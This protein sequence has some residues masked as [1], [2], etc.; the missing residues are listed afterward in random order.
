MAASKFQ[1]PPQAPLVFTTTGDAVKQ[2]MDKANDESKAIVD[3]LVAEVK[4]ENATFSSVIEPALKSD[5]E[6]NKGR[7]TSV[8][9]QYVSSDAAVRDGSTKA[10]E[11]W[12]S[13]NIDA[14]MRDDIFK[15]VDA[16]YNTRASQNLDTEKLR[17]LEKER[18]AYVRNGLLLPAG[19]QRDHFK[20]VQKRLSQLCIESAKNHNEEA[21]GIWFTPAE[22][23]GVPKD[24]VDIDGL[25][26]GS[27]ENEGKVRVSFKYNHLIP[28][29]KY[30]VNE[31][32]RKV[33]QIAE[34]NK[35]RAARVS[36]LKVG[37]IDVLHL[38]QQKRAAL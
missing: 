20:D 30:A 28:I 9:Y 35:V 27:G 25:E 23:D 17:I 21:G 10:D 38:G 13:Y 3:K 24:D 15:L 2:G 16:A 31:E 7:V 4:P 12:D 18:Q 32:T 33:Y 37:D 6:L 11:A 26:R 22:L 19:P 5:N 1:N 36:S 34:S 14:K 8:F 29:L